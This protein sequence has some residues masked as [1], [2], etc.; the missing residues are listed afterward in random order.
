MIW[1]IPTSIVLL[2]ILSSAVLAVYTAETRYSTNPY[3]IVQ[4]EIV[5]EANRY[6]MD[7]VNP[8]GG[9][10]MKG[11]SRG[12]FGLKGSE[13]GRS[14]LETN[15]FIPMGRTPGRISNTYA[16]ARG[17]QIINEFVNLEHV[18]LQLVSRPQINGTP[19]GFARVISRKRNDVN[20]AEGTV[21]LRTKD[22]PKIGPDYV[23]EAWLL[24]EDTSTS[25]SVGIFQPSTIG[26]VA[27]LRHTVITPLDPFESIIVTLEPFPDKDPN[28]GQVVLSGNLKNNVRTQ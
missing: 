10:G 8:F 14:N 20:I 12:S 7:Y 23:Y 5:F 1:R 21:L 6:G 3:E 11:A 19:S 9:Y 25:M 13:E 27:T 16:S 22:L 2:L 26:R 28:P 18:D 24:D 17:Y 4:R 15:S